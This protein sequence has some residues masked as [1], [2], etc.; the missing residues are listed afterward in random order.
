[1]PQAT[2]VC[3]LL[4]GV[5]AVFIFRVEW[6]L[7]VEAE[8]SLLPFVG[9]TAVLDGVVVNDPERRSNSLHAQVDVYRIN[10]D[11]ALGRLLAILPR[12]EE[13]AYNDEVS[14]RGELKEPEAFETDTG[15]VFDY[16]GY[17]RV[18]GVS[19]IMPFATLLE[20]EDRGWS[21]LRAL[22][23]LKH[24]FER[25]LERAVSEP[26]AAL[27]L[28]LLLGERRGLPEPITQA[29]I[30]AGLIHVVVLSGYNISLV[31][32]SVLRVLGGVLPRR[33][34][35]WGGGVTIVLFALMVG[36]GAATIRACL[37]GL[38]GVLARY[39]NRP[40]AALRA[41]AA[42]ALAMALWNPL[43]LMHDSGFALSIIATLGLILLSPAIELRLAWVPAW[44]RFNLRSIAASTIAVQVFVLP[45][46]LYY[47]GVLS[48]V[49]LPA[50]LLALPAVPFAMFFGFIT[51]TLG[52]LHP[53]VATLPALAVSLLLQWILAVAQWFAALPFA[54]SVVPPFPVWIMFFV[55]APLTALAVW[56]YSRSRRENNPV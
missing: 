18:R 41:L 32:E 39:L 51:G 38:I 1:M 16:A 7:E 25:A 45:A 47:T 36:G 31:S 46:L 19:A 27:L 40:Q 14:I 6:F 53:L 4:L 22:Y 24:S 29:F 21:P 55:Y 35:L 33:V 30:I 37:M 9:K 8:R 54:W 12:D 43:V 3:L 5:A 52:L 26:R 56:I 49:S 17:L 15:R 44:K 34:A 50:N 10:G 48:F 13:L 20:Q 2:K 28:G 23:L 11:P 42:A